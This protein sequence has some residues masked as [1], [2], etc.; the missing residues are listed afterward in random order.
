MTWPKEITVVGARDMFAGMNDGPNGRHCA[1][2]WRNA[3]MP[4]RA[5]DETDQWRRAYIE[6]A[7]AK[8]ELLSYGNSVVVVN[9]STCK[10]NA[11]RAVLLNLTWKALGYDVPE[12]ACKWPGGSKKR[13]AKRT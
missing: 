7:I 4:Q 6:A 13:G 9:D 3:D 8:F 5:D 12:S 10:T 1:I 2:G 11:Q